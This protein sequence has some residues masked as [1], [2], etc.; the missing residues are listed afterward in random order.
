MAIKKIFV[1]FLLVL[2]LFTFSFS[3]FGANYYVPT[4]EE[5]QLLTNNVFYYSSFDFENETITTQ[6]L[7]F[8]SSSDFSYPSLV[9]NKFYFIYMTPQGT[10]FC[11]PVQLTEI[12][13]SGIKVS[14]FGVN[15]DL[16]NDTTFVEPGCDMGLI[17]LYQGDSI[18]CSLTRDKSFTLD[19]GIVA[20]SYLPRTEDAFKVSVKN[21]L[22]YL[23]SGIGNLISVFL[24]PN[25][26]LFPLIQLLLLGISI[27]FLLFVVKI[28]RRF[29]W[30]D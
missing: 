7:D 26:I 13:V 5:F 8:I 29:I 17:F 25:G 24:S 1:L 28:I 11:Y 18:Y 22:A 12:S 16:Y 2:I 10:L 9:S 20:L 23:V 14:L 15:L 21:A 27:T 30:G 3:C 4:D 6:G 19:S